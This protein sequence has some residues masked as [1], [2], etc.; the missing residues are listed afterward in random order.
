MSLYRRGKTWWYVFEF[1]G[2]KVQESSGHQN[3]S[4]A[5]RAET[6]RRTDLLDRAPRVRKTKARSLKFEEFTK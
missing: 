3:K 5:L 2:R 1:G 6:R 4:A